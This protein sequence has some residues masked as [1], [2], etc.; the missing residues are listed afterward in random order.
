LGQA[1]P[2]PSP[3][4]IE[5]AQLRERIKEEFARSRQTYGSLRLAHALR[6]PGE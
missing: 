2:L 5:T 3:E 1:T 6:C 4:H